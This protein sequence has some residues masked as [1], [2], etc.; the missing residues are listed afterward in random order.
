MLL[1]GI[2]LGGYSAR[3][4]E[5]SFSL[6]GCTI[7]DTAHSPDAYPGHWTLVSEEAS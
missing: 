2:T 3:A 5:A 1:N 7:E 6:D 4:D